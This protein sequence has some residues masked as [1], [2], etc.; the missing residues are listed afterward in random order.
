MNTA[1]E[2][3]L[4]LQMDAKNPKVQEEQFI[5]NIVNFLNWVREN[6]PKEFQNPTIKSRQLEISKRLILTLFNELALRS[7]KPMKW[8]LSKKLEKERDDIIDIISKDSLVFPT[9]VTSKNLT[10][11]YHLFNDAIRIWSGN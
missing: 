9:S 6:G 8:K 11:D 3:L 2:K 1:K 7:D 4:Q 5:I 10:F